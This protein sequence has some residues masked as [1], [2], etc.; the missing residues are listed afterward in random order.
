MLLSKIP[1]SGRVHVALCSL[2]KPGAGLRECYGEQWNEL[3]TCKVQA[4]P[5]RAV[6]GMLAW[7]GEE[8]HQEG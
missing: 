1:Q 5:Y 4:T 7:Q 2:E 8:G 3:D 6:R